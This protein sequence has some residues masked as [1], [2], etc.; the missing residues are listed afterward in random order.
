M[1]R[2]RRLRT[3]SRF[4]LE[5]LE[6]RALLSG[7]EVVPE[8]PD[9]GEVAPW[10]E[11]SKPAV[12][13]TPHESNDG[14]VVAPPQEQPDDS[15]IY[16]T[17]ADRSPV[18][19]GPAQLAAARRRAERMA[20]RWE[21]RDAA[22]PMITET[23]LLTR[24]DQVVGFAL[25]FDSPMRADVATDPNAYRAIRIT[26]PNTWLA[27]LTYQGD[28]PQIEELRIRE[29]EYQAADRRAIIWLQ[30]PRRAT[31]QFRVGVL[32]Q[33]TP[34]QR[35]TRPLVLGPLTDLQGRVVR[36]NPADVRLPGRHILFT[37]PDH[38]RPFDSN[39]VQGD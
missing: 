25:S 10:E 34:I 2:S 19:R 16:Y 21:R 4:H 38:S 26:K 23:T 3:F 35:R 32:T 24:G 29:V 39:W 28:G 6:G 17:T 11:P 12:D 1:D 30:D 9:V 27:R 36:H 18:R 15:M 31:G 22:G 20:D 14:E 37:Q 8:R 5:G 33:Q 13:A 7:V